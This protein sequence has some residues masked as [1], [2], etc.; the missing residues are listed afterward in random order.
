MNTMTVLE[1]LAKAID[2]QHYRSGG[3]IFVVWKELPD[4]RFIEVDENSV[5]VYPSRFAH[6]LGDESGVENIY[7]EDG[8]DPLT[9]LVSLFGFET[10][11]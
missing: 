10:V 8:D 9:V 7:F 5:G 3:G 2:G 11:G 6:E 1:K 4:G